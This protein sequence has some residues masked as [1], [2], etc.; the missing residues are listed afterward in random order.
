MVRTVYE[1]SSDDDL[2]E[3]FIDAMAE[4]FGAAEEV[5]PGVIHVRELAAG[6]IQNP[7]P[8]PFELHITRAQLRSVAYSKYDT[9]DDS[10]GEVTVEAVDPVLTGL[11]TFTFETQEIMDSEYRVNRRRLVFDAGPMVRS[12]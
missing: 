9:F 11:D 8:Q 3:W 1:T 10:Q 6:G 4:E 2:Y 5:A 7:D 12:K